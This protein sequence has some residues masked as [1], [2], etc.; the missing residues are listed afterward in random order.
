MEE[1]ILTT[2]DLKFLLAGNK[3]KL[4]CGHYCTIGHNFANTLIIYSTGGGKIETFCHNC[5][6]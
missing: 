1:E 5:Y 6:N 2:E 3:L 4:D